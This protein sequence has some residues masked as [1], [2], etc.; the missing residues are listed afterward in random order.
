MVP[1]INYRGGEGYGHRE[2][3]EIAKAMVA[4]VA[5]LKC[6]WV[7]PRISTRWLLLKKT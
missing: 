6:A 7:H 3:I 4:N 2:L 1:K 5:G